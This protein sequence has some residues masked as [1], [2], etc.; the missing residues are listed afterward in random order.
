MVHHRQRLPLGLEAGDN[1]LRVH[2]Q[3][4]D[5]ERDLAFDRFALL[6]HVDRAE[7]AFTDQLKE[8]VLVDLCAGLLSDGGGCGRSGVVIG[9]VRE[10]LALALVRCEHGV[11][12]RAHLR[13]AAARAFEIG[14]ARFAVQLDRAVEDLGDS[15]KVPGLTLVLHKGRPHS[16]PGR[17]TFGRTPIAALRSSGRRRG[18]RRSA[19]S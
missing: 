10:K 9:R 3:F 18:L 19:R 6:G 15:F 5:L 12:L 4:D 8:F 16:T 13:I 17:A 14:A 1:L 2:A 11:D 7:A